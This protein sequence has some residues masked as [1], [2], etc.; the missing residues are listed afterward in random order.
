MLG[1]DPEQF[2]YQFPGL[3][4]NTPVLEK[5]AAG[6][7]MLTI[8]PERDGIVRRVPMIMQAQDT[9]MPSLSFEM[10]RVVTGT[11]TIFIKTDVAGVKGPGLK[12]IQIPTDPNGQLLVHFAR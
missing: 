4:R 6:H 9:T 3:L 8:N 5:A 7:G 1:K 10:L 2:M 12:G 11:D